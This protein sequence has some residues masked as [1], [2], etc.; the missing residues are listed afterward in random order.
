MV[1]NSKIIINAI[2]SPRRSVKYYALAPDG[3]TTA[4]IIYY[5]TTVKISDKSDLYFCFYYRKMEKNPNI[6][7][8][9]YVFGR[10]IAERNQITLECCVR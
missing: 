3:A 5:R 7:E 8:R 6:A 2:I 4:R 9:A 10:K 1:Y